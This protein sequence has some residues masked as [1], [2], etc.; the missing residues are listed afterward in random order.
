M[1]KINI[2]LDPK[3]NPLFV[4]VLQI[5]FGLVCLGIS[6]F[7]FIFNLK[8]DYTDS[9]L[10]ITVAL[11]ACFGIY[12][13]LSGFGKTKRYIEINNDEIFLKKNALMPFSKLKNTDIRKIESLPLNIIFRMADGRK[14]ILRFG[15]NYPEVIPVVKDKLKEFSEI[16][17]IQFD[18]ENDVEQDLL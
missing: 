12:L 13:I 15:I 3:D 2:P 14:T 8:A 7:W 9:A 4:K 18:A 11:L 1:E 5:L 6:I 10:W 16:N 17:S